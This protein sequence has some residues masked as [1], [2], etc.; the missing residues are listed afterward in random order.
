MEIKLILTEPEAD[1]LIRLIDVAVRHDGLVAAESAVVIF[2]KLVAAQ[3]RA[4]ADAV[5][6]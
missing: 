6:A 3:E 2:K 5:P 1:A 4:K